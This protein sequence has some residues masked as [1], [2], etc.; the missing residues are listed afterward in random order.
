MNQRLAVWNVPTRIFLW[1]PV[2]AFWFCYPSLGIMRPNSNAAQDER[3]H[4]D[5]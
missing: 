3:Q 4:D 2:V 1:L 5:V